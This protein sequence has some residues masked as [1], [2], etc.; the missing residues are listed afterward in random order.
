MAVYVRNK[1]LYNEI[2]K[3]KDASCASPELIGMFFKISEHLSTKFTYKQSADRD[4]CIMG[5]VEDAYK[6]FWNFDP[7]KYTNAFSYCTQVIKMG[8]AKQNRILYAPYFIKDLNYSQV[9]T[10][11]I[12]SL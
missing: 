10:N 6:Y 11:N 1:D 8:M 3:C 12:F 2:V 4:D 5:G 9:S 7:S